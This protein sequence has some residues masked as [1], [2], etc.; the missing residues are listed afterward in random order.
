MITG[1]AWALVL[2][3]G[4]GTRLRRFTT[5]EDGNA[6]PKQFCSFNGDPSLLQLAHARAER[7]VG[8]DR[9]V[10]IV[11]AQ[12]RAWWEPDL[13]AWPERNVVVQ[14]ANRGTAVG[15]LLPLLAILARDPAATILVVPSDHY[16]EDER[17]LERATRRAIFETARTP[18]RIALLGIAP[19]AP[20]PGLGWIVP[21]R[22]GAGADAV[23]GVERFVEKPPADEA[24]RLMA[25]GALWNSFLFAAWGPTLLELF[26]RRLPGVTSIVREAVERP[27][28]L[29][30]A[31]EELETRDFSRDILEGFESRLGVLRVAACG[32]SDLGTPERVVAC[33]ERIAPEQ[34]RGPAVRAGLRVPATLP[35]P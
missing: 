6:V 30:R 33:W 34:R 16:F 28:G 14:P 25:R 10:T 2:A 13:L 17:V 12:H 7:V 29:R 15:I 4:D 23:S 27:G 21:S 19:D 5:D 22:R 9:I 1:S 8:R 20:E 31:Y 3:A 18:G 35:A 11:A 26:W 24:A 32:W